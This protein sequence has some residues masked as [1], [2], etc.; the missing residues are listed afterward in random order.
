MRPTSGRRRTQTR[1]PRSRTVHQLRG[2][3]NVSQE[4]EQGREEGRTHHIRRRRHPRWRC[5]Q[6]HRWKS[7]LRTA[8][9]WTGEKDA[10]SASRPADETEGEE[11]YLSVDAL[12]SAAGSRDGAGGVGRGA[13]AALGELLVA[14]CACAAGGSEP[15]GE[16]GVASEAVVAALKKEDIQ[17]I[18]L[19]LDDGRRRT[20]SGSSVQSPP[21]PTRL[22]QL[23]VPA[24]QYPARRDIK[25]TICRSTKRGEDEPVAQ[26]AL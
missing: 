7:K 13:D 5:S 3:S 11:T 21:A 14:A 15:A 19:P 4:V 8:R 20:N 23:A 22:A 26:V 2:E 18:V 24:L 17:R 12:E 25:S 1:M 16:G 10:S 9:G 6:L